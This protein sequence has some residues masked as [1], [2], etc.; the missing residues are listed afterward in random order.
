MYLVDTNVISE[1]RKGKRADAG[2]LAFFGKAAQFEQPVYVS[3]VTLGEIRRGIDQIQYRGDGAQARLLE[4]W[5][6]LVLGE[7]SDHILTF[8]ATE[9]QVWGRLMVPHPHNALDKQ[10]AA[11][12]LTYGL[13]LVTRNTKDFSHCGVKLLNPFG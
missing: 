5:F 2:V 1:L 9:A 8:T 4:D 3:V 11:I 12:A 7:Y 6:E 13:T 10:I